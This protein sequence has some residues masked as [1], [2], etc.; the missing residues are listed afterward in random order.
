M[1]P[2][3]SLKI[4]LF[5]YCIFLNRV[6]SVMAQEDSLLVSGFYQ[7]LYNY[8]FLSAD[9][10][11]RS[12]GNQNYSPRV[13]SIL[14]ISLAWWQIISGEGSQ[15]KIDSLFQ[16]IDSEIDLIENKTQKSDHSQDEYI[17]LII[18]YSYKSRLH[19]YQNNRLAS[20]NAFKHSFKYFEELE[21]CESGYCD[22]HNFI[23]GMYYTLGGHLQ[24]QFSPVFL[25]GLDR[26]YADKEKGYTLLDQC[27]RSRNSQIRTES[28]YFLM[29]LYYEVQKDP[30]SASKYS[31]QLVNLYPD[32]LVFRFNHILI[33]N[34]QGK[35]VEADTAY[36]IFLI[37]ADKNTQLT[38]CQK[39]HFSE[40]YSKL[41]R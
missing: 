22:M 5:F 36:R 32:N 12:I 24:E 13:V 9:T 17:Q 27:T 26:N 31:N 10:V 38:P 35:Y 6:P 7:N 3:K 41:K 34:E 40:E 1:L 25:L 30:D 14:E 15:E 29:K 28:I 20:F 23:A 2:I 4:I 33:L 21:P 19:N 8:K 11:L 37:R 16:K 39:K 18:L